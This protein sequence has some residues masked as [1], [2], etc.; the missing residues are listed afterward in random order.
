MQDMTGYGS[1]MLWGEQRVRERERERERRYKDRSRLEGL[2][3]SFSFQPSVLSFQLCDCQVLTAMQIF[4]SLPEGMSMP[5]LG[6]FSQAIFPRYSRQRHYYA[7]D[8]RDSP[9]NKI[10]RS[11]SSKGTSHEPSCAIGK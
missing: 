3:I 2:D 9:T 4:S 5:S 7:E 8:S 6:S 10:L 11:R 1:T